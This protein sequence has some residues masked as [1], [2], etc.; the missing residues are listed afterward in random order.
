MPITPGGRLGPYEILAPL[1]AGGMGEVWHARD[2]RLDREVALKVVPEEVLADADR[3][4]RFAREAR[5][6][7][8][9]NHPAIAAIYAFEE[10]PG[11]PARHVLAMELLRG[12]TLREALRRG[13]LPESRVRELG[14]AVA[15][16][17]AAAHGRGIVHRDLKPE[18]LFLPSDAPVK[19]L[20]FGLAKREADAAGGDP[21]AP[22]AARTEAG[23]VLGTSGYM[24]P[25]QISG[26][27]AGPRSDLF[28]LGCV[29]YEM[30]SGRR[31]FA[32]DT[33][34]ETFAAILRDAPEPLG[35]GTSP[36]LARIVGRCLEKRPE[37]RFPSARDLASALRETSSLP[38]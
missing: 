14:A 35:K 20:D 13:P 23:V 17:L 30:L 5:L 27:P 6:L 33:L 10:V 2:T 29:L 19:I 28:A 25:E 9:L 24:S 38:G 1:G 26:A 7:A 11:P 34:P 22:T 8:A 15:D 16:G 31:A 21:E 37:A 18:N 4:E 32:R 3:R 36:A 12:E